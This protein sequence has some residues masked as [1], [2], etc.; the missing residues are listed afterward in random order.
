MTENELDPHVAEWLIRVRPGGA[1]VSVEQARIAEQ[2][3]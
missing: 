1:A 2:G 3:G